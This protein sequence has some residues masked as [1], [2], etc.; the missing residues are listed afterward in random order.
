MEVDFRYDLARTLLCYLQAR[1]LF[2]LIFINRVASGMDTTVRAAAFDCALCCEIPQDGGQ[3]TSVQL[4]SSSTNSKGQENKE[5]CSEN[6]KQINDYENKMV[7]ASI[8]YIF[9]TTFE[10]LMHAFEKRLNVWYKG[11]RAGANPGFFKGKL[12]VSNVFIVI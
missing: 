11:T 8:F 1:I 3:F 5:A 9:D 7:N 10:C 12:A 4:Q 2:I 6:M